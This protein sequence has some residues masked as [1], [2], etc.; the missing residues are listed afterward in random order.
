MWSYSARERR[1]APPEPSDTSTASYDGTE[2]V[3]HHSK[4]HQARPARRRQ[5]SNNSSIPAPTTT[6]KDREEQGS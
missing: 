2:R 5:D 1:P 3:V 6:P 4:P